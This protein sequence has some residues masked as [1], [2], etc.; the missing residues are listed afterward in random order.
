MEFK[1]VVRRRRMVRNFTSDPVDPDS[2]ARIVESARRSP[3]AGFA[4][5]QYFVV[6]TDA[7]TRRAVAELADEP[8]YVAAGFDPWISSAP[9]HVVVCTSEADYHHRY[10]EPDKLGPDGTEI[11]WPVP[12]WWVD[13]GAALMA[14]LLAA[15]DEGLAAGFFGVDRLEGLGELIDL[16]PEVAP[17]GIVTLGHP[18]PDRRSRSLARGWKPAAEVVHH[19]RWG[20]PLY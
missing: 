11:D 13:A 15:V 5:G 17:I 4:Q 9:V 18:A 1:E 8:T 16:P 3:S 20:Q 6:L 10:Q 7:A 19:E 12:F 2:V 14:L